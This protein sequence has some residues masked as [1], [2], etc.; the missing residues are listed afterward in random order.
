MQKIT[1]SNTQAECKVKYQGLVT[2]E[3]RTI[4][5]RITRRN[6]QTFPLLIIVVDLELKITVPMIHTTSLD[7]LYNPPQLH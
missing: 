4:H 6:R 1:L 2:G 3:L 7:T 5:I